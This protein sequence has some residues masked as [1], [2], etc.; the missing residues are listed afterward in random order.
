M[1]K[2]YSFF[3]SFLQKLLLLLVI[4]WLVIAIFHINNLLPSV[5]ASLFFL[6]LVLLLFV[7]R[8]QLKGFYQFLMQHK[9]ALMLAA[10]IF[11][12]VML[13]AAQLLIRRD[14]AVVFTGAFGYL[15]ESSISNYLTRNPNNMFLF[16]YERFFFK[17]FGPSG[18]WIMQALNLFYTDVT[19]WI[20]Y[21]G[22]LKYL[23][24]KTADMTFFLYLLLLGFSPYFFSMYTDILP[25][26]LIALQIFLTLAIFQEKETNKISLKTVLLALIT[27]LASLIRPTVLILLI[28]FFG[29]LFLRKGFKKAFL[30]LGVFSLA[31]AASYFSLNHLIKNQTEIPLVKGEGLAKGPLLFIDLGLTD[32]GHN[33]EDMKEG[34]LAYVE[35]SRR[36]DYNNGMFA[37]ENIIK[38]IER[39]LSEFTPW[40]F[41]GHLYYKESLTVA[42]GTLGWLYRSVENEKTPYISPLYDWTKSQAWAQFI[43]DYFL[44]TDKKSF[45]YYALVKQLFWIFLAFDLVLAMW[46]FRAEDEAL[47]LLALAVF[48]GLLFLQIFEGGKTRYLI[49]FL[50]QIVLLASLGLGRYSFRGEKVKKI[51][52]WKGRKSQLS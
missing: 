20:L 41:L 45:A 2:V 51:I 52:A 16:L 28:A 26:P 34:L 18:L 17:I 22:S 30:V 4:H 13:L 8:K 15:K 50:P 44:N 37:Q 21:K 24:Q 11:Q 39:R 43:R 48:G 19:A 27:G 23:G 33:Q 12:L 9:R 46:K 25:L 3:F 29:L 40:T 38:D 32:T 49:Q 5:G 36:A 35:P 1:N 10:I 42:E 14:A 6:A 7:C 31:F 47:N